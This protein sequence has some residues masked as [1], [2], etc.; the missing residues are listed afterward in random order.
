MTPESFKKISPR[1]KNG[2]ADPALGAELTLRLRR[3][4]DQGNK[5]T[6]PPTH[7]IGCAPET[8]L[9]GEDAIDLP[10]LTQKTVGFPCHSPQ[11]P[12]SASQISPIVA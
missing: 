1:V 2:I 7:R 10:D 4:T 8:V 12:R 6:L 5:P 9:A 3:A 11:T